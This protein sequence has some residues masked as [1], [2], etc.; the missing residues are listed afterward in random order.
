VLVSAA[1]VPL[2]TNEVAAQ[3]PVPGLHAFIFDIPKDTQQLPD[4]R[5]LKPVGEIRGAT[6][7][8]SPRSY[9][10]GFPGV[11]HRLEWYALQFDGPFTVAQ[12]GDFTFRLECD[13][14][15]RLFIDEQLVVDHDGIHPPSSKSGTIHLG[16]G[17]HSIQVQY[18]QGPKEQIALRVFAAQGGQAER[19]FSQ[20]L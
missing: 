3:P 19:I 9:A 2:A 13:D 17:G 10:S 11:T 6:L 8:V 12:A 20:R 1:L 4:F 7:D 5:Q 14:G 15:A 16:A 18:F